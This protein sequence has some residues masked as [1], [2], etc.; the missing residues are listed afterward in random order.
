[1]Q[2]K[3]LS[4]KRPLTLL[5]LG[6]FSLGLAQAAPTVFEGQLA[7]GMRVLVQEDHR[8][9]IVTSQVWYRVGSGDEPGGMTG[10]SHM[11]EHMMFKGTQTLAPGKFSE[12]IAEHG[13]QENAFTSRDYTAYFQTLAREHLD[14][15]M[16]LEADRM[17]NLKLRAEDLAKEAEVVKE[18]RRMRTDDNPSAKLMEQF[19]ATAY[20]NGGYHHP[21]IGWMDD[22]N[23]Y[24]INKLRAW[25]QAHYAPNNATLVVV[26]DVQPAEVMQLAEK[27][28]APLKP[29]KLKE[30][31]YQDA[32]PQTGE[33][34]IT[35]RA[36]AKLPTL[37]MGYRVPSL[38]SAS[39]DKEV[40]AW[41]PYALEVLAGVLDGGQSA[42]LT[43][44]LVRGEQIAGEIGVGYS[45]DSR[46]SDLFTIYAVP[47]AQIESAKIEQAIRN[48]IK[49]L[50][51]KPVSEDELKRVKAQVIAA[52]VYGRDSVFYQAM[53]LGS[54][55]AAG[56]GHTRLNDAIPAIEAITAEQVQAVAK[57][58]LIDEHLTVGILDP[59]PMT[60]AQAK[61]A[62]MP[63][64][65]ATHVR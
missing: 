31:A 7:N 22:I 18:E 25:Y 11:L 30:R 56:L 59:L 43:K 8:A 62:T 27:Y 60:D 20:L 33:R 54:Y 13:G 37:M 64:Q 24:D 41:E 28:F 58:Y 26:G 12:I 15:S 17:R 57:K 63:M 48:E 21:V 23:Q 1:M 14:V 6:V 19:H 36:P 16:R 4:G 32:V 39:K 40:A 29:F 61:Q 35:V 53:R 47:N 42:R 52:D 45:L 9:P 49:L 46:L 51:E 5:I 3:Q 50:R 2:H 34:R 55:E 10:I 38:L 44:N 65:G